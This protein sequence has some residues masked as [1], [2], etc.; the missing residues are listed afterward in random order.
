MDALKSGL[1]STKYMDELYFVIC[2]KFDCG[3]KV[4]LCDIVMNMYVVVRFGVEY[5][6]F[7]DGDYYDVACK[8]LAKEIDIFN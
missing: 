5:V 6:G 7:V 4:V 2:V 1:V 3:E 8:T